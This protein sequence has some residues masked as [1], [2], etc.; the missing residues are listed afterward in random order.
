M[1]DRERDPALEVESESGQARPFVRCAHCQT[2]NHR[3]AVSCT[4]CGRSMET[5]EQRA[6]NERFWDQRRK[7]AAADALEVEKLRATLA[8]GAQDF[9]QQL[10]ASVRATEL[11]R[12]AG[13][14]DSVGT[15]EGK[16]RRSAGL[17][18]LQLIPNER[19]RLGVSV[20]LILIGCFGALSLLAGRAPWAWGF[21]FL[22]AALL[23]YPRLSPSR[24]R[25]SWFERLGRRDG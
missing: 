24:Q 13:L 20:G 19:V 23:F 21:V 8:G 25:R 9:G 12:L 14:D 6:F 3:S 5:D 22:V 7:E 15:R 10:A 17:E 2:D 1:S 16:G 11:K 4:S 18:A